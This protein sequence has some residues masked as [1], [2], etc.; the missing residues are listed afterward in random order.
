MRTELSR[1]IVPIAADA[2]DLSSGPMVARAPD[3][4]RVAPYEP[5]QHGGLAQVDDGRLLRLAQNAETWER[6]TL[7]HPGLASTVPPCCRTPTAKLLFVVTHR[8]LSAVAGPLTLPLG[9]GESI[10]RTRAGFLELVAAAGTTRLGDQHGDLQ[11]LLDGA[12]QRA[13]PGAGP[14]D[15]VDSAPLEALLASAVHDFYASPNFTGGGDAPSTRGGRRFA[16]T[17][18]EQVLVSDDPSQ[19]GFECLASAAF[20]L[21]LSMGLIPPDL[22]RQELERRYTQIHGDRAEGT[23]RLG[24]QFTRSLRGGP[25]TRPGEE[26][27]GA[28]ATADFANQLRADDWAKLTGASRGHYSVRTLRT[29]DDVVANFERGGGAVHTTWSNGGHYFV[30]SGASREGGVVT[31]DQDD[32]LHGS[33]ALRSPKNA[34]PN[35]TRY[36]DWEHGRFW[37]LDRR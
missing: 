24:P 23:P 33:R 19:R 1:T 9:P 10:R 25:A 11:R 28:S 4:T 29:I 6:L 8:E 7:A 5:P 32:S 31:V 22:T 16:F 17:T 26:R 18:F 27:F 12:Q 30:L 3:E 36:D 14:F 35:A 20:H 13:T 34:R 21:Y 2:L 37:T 15:L